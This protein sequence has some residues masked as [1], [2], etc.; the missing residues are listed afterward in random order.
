MKYKTLEDMA[1]AFK[2]IVIKEKLDDKQAS[3]LWI[4]MLEAYKSEKSE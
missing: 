3:W 2:A 4:D 1:A